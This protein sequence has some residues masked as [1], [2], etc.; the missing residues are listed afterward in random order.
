M[1][2]S[3]RL[4]GLHRLTKLKAG[5]EAAGKKEQQSYDKK[6]MQHFDGCS[7]LD[8]A[9]VVNTL[10]QGFGHKP[11][12]QKFFKS[13]EDFVAGCGVM[14]ATQIADYALQSAQ[15]QGILKGMTMP[16]LLT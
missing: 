12:I 4:I 15:I 16:S 10:H 1:H 5:V 6:R 9:L 3:T 11:E 13:P 14:S 8:K 2:T 7:V